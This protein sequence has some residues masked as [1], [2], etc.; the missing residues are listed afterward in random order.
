MHRDKSLKQF[1]LH[2]LLGQDFSLS[3][4]GSN[5]ITHSFSSFNLL[6]GN[7]NN[8]IPSSSME[9]GQNKVNESA[10][11]GRYMHFHRQSQKQ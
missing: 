11:Q 10:K 6:A 7:N 4:S 3:S 5:G 1:K 9:I 8:Y 2:Q